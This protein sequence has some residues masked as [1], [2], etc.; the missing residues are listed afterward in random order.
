MMFSRKI[1]I[2]PMLDWTDR[3]DRFFLR[4]ISSHAVLYTEMVT[5]GAIIHG[6]KQRHLDFDE[7][8]QPLAI[9]LGGSDPSDLAKC[10]VIAEKW[11][12]QEI[13]LNVG[14]PSDRVQSGKFGA[15]LMAEPELVRDC[16]KAMID[17][18][19]VPVSVKTRIGID[20]QDSFDEL[21]H[22]ISTVKGSGCNIFIIHARKAWLDGLSP[23]ENRDIP[24]L[25][26]DRVYKIKELF[27]ELEVIINGGIKTLD[28]AEEHLKYVDGVMIG[29]EAY[30]NPYL[31]SDVD[32]RFYGDAH[33][34]PTRDE[35][36][37]LL[38]PYIK[39]HLE[40]GGKLGQ[41]SRHIL[42]LYQSKPGGKYWRRIISEQAHIAGAGIE[43]LDNALAAVH[44]QSERIRNRLVNMAND[45]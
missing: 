11:G 12:Y 35:I 8:E 9:Q 42:G 2:A 7:A 25:C 44:E 24:P 41:I 23:K 36:I 26:Y 22:F 18:V 39:R 45:S 28:E 1:S 13:N 43:V 16:L 40:L 27:P 29:R 37:T 34:K 14:C 33:K 3:H 10:A 38:K 30:Q 15:C 4:L 21:H 19:T 31:L 17:K 20:R 5:T 32:Q 6:D